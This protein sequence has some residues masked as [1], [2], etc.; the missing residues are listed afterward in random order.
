[1]LARFATWLLNHRGKALAGIL[2]V[3]TFFAYQ[4]RNLQVETRFRDLLPTRHPYIQLFNQ[5]PSFTDPLEVQI[6]IEVKEGTVFNRRTLEKVSRITLGLDFIPGVNHSGI[7]SLASRQ[8]THVARTKE[9]IEASSLMP[10]GL[11]PQTEEEVGR[12]QRLAFETP[13]V[14]GVLV[15][16]DLKAT[17]IRVGFLEH[18]DY[19]RVF[20]EIQA[21]VQK[22][23]GDIHAIYAVGD[24]V[25][26]GWVYYY[27]RETLFVLVLTLVGIALLL[28]VYMRGEIVGFVVP[29]FVAAVSSIWG[30]GLVALLGINFEPLTLVVPMLIIARSFSHGVQATQRFLE[31]FYE[32]RDRREA[33]L[34]SFLSIFPPGTL[35]IITDAVG[36]FSIMLAP[37]PVMQ[38]LALS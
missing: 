31:E 20:Q 37:I 33:C 32:T 18:L 15:S 30:I 4:L 2:L 27:E 19:T 17:A 12:I 13:G 6:I 7:Y 34:R 5:Y 23:S 28:I 1:M 16:R 14:I 24:P 26:V 29:I 25:L 11:P 8:V 35:G 36:L 22:E 38:K 10:R 9:G 21:I 3:T